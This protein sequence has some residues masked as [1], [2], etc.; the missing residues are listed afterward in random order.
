[1]GKVSGSKTAGPRAAPNQPTRI[2]AC[3]VQSLAGCHCTLPVK[4]PND[5]GFARIG[6]TNVINRREAS[7]RLLSASLG[8]LCLGI[9][10]QLSSK[11][12]LWHDSKYSSSGQ[13]RSRGLDAQHLGACKI[14]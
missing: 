3:A 2:F 11:R 10:A 12:G 7:I 6:I 13:T 9:A 14:C 5:K 1:M 8:P 4:L